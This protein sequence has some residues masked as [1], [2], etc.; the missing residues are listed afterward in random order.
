VLLGLV[1]GGGLRQ[2][3][4]VEGVHNGVCFMFSFNLNPTENSLH[5]TPLLSE[6]NSPEA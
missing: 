4:C 6:G 2:E 5:T 1:A 3:G